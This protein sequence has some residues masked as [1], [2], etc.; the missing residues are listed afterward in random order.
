MKAINTLL[1]VMFLTGILALSATQAMADEVVS[2][3]EQSITFEETYL[4]DGE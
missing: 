4:D 2:D 1:A 3:E